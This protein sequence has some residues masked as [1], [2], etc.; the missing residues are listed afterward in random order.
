M[1][2]QVTIW[3]GGL[4]HACGY[5]PT[6]GSAEQEVLIGILCVGHRQSLRTMGL[7]WAVIYGHR[8]SQTS[9]SL[10]L[11]ALLI[12]QLLLPLVG[13]GFLLGLKQ[14]HDGLHSARP[15]KAVVDAL[16]SHIDSSVCVRAALY[17]SRSLAHVFAHSTSLIRLLSL[18]NFAGEGICLERN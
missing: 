5:M 16:V 7:M 8:L 9:A 3:R 13:W 11:L 17:S 10:A 6:L 14:L 18:P 4:L 15:H 1:S 12:R 2:H